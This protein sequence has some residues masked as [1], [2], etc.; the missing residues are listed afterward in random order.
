MLQLK[1]ILSILIFALGLGASLLLMA[2]P[3]LYGATATGAGTGTLLT[4]D[5]T[6]GNFT[7]WAN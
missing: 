2:A 7:K 6:T 4:I 3:I 1:S 5:P